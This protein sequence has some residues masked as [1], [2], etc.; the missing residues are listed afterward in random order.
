MK[1]N[2]NRSSPSRVACAGPHV[3]TSHLVET[4]LSPWVWC[5]LSIHHQKGY[6]RPLNDI[7]LR[8]NCQRRCSIAD[9]DQ[10]GSYYV[11]INGDIGVRTFHP[12]SC[13]PASGD[14]DRWEHRI[15]RAHCKLLFSASLTPWMSAT[16]QIKL[17]TIRVLRTQR[18]WNNKSGRKT[19]ATWATRSRMH[20]QT[21]AFKRR[22]RLF[23]FIVI[24]GA[25][26]H[27]QSTHM[28]LLRFNEF[29]RDTSRTCIARNTGSRQQQQKSN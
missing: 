26:F 28:H 18:R 5:N 25:L 6:P 11:L 14:A 3:K 7:F 29:D 1:I 27:R 9:S 23:A 15:F 4:M 24:P 22:T 2:V 13:R 19:R 20:S 16:K 8:P 21:S 17:L 12:S 10:T